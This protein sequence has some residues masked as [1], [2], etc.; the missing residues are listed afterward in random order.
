VYPEF[1]LL[2]SE[3]TSA[4]A[5]FIFKDILCRWGIIEE[6]V[7]DNGPPFIA[8]LNILAKK[9]KIYHIRITP[10]NSQANGIIERRHFNVREALVKAAGGD[11]TRWAMIAPSVFWAERITAQKLTGYSQYYL[12]HSIEPLLPFNLA[13]GTFLASP[14]QE[15]IS[16]GDLITYRAHM[17]QKHLDDLEQV[18]Q[19][20]HHARIASAHQF[21]E[22]YKGTIRDF[23]FVPNT[24]VL[25][26]N[27]K[28]NSSIGYKSR[29]RYLGPM[30][31]I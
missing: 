18:Q 11:K 20:L 24:L 26:W 9:Y 10:Y 17:L 6:L 21:K 22:K 15:R 8:A 4:L 13:E 1:R 16:T 7:T 23:D 29:P 14:P 28:I 5:A 31:V 3:N 27:L 12:A 30:A 25:V 19:T 2:H